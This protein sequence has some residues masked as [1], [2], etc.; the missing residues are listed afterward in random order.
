MA[1]ECMVWVLDQSENL[2]T[3]EKFVLEH[4]PYIIQLATS[5]HR[6]SA[7]TFFRVLF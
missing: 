1:I 7:Y 2:T 5:L 6:F 3:N 4:A